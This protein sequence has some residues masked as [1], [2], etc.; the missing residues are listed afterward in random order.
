ML[1]LHGCDRP[2]CCNPRHLRLG[3]PGDN[4]RDMDERGRRVVA[5][6]AGAANGAAKLREEHL[7]VIVERLKAGWNNKQISRGLP[8][9]HA[10][11]S[12]I[13]T[14]QSWAEQSAALGWTPKPQFQRKRAA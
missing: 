9:G 13:R 4:I 5:D 7:P 11:I 6:Q 2:Q 10:L 3:T 12:R 8:V 14:G 1:V